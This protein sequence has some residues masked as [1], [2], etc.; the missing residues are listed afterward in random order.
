MHELWQR[1]Q[2]SVF[3]ITFENANGRIS[4]GTGFKAGGYLITNNHVIQ[5]PNSRHITLR[6]VGVDGH[7]T[8][9]EK[10]FGHL[11]FRSFLVD[12]DPVESWDY[13]VLNIPDIRFKEIPSLDLLDT[14]DVRIGD[15]IAIFGYQFDQP[16]LSMHSGYLSSQYKK[17]SVHYLQLDSSINHGN[18]GGPL[19]HSQTG[20][21]FGVVTRKA[22]GLT[23]QFDDLL[24]SFKQ[25]ISELEKLQSSG[26][27]AILAGINP[28]ASTMAMQK[29]MEQVARELSRSANV[30]IGY[31]YHISKVR[32]SIKNLL[33]QAS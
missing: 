11:E 3:S 9:Y 18:S 14:D 13:A 32:A 5:V 20:R 10:R 21:V 31:A 26:G 6:S 29:Q 28:V 22:T 19:V 23:K 33:Q 16:Q 24:L 1:C 27:F 7:T 25:N 2:Q 4:S 12:G 30:G 17:A 8:F 15:A